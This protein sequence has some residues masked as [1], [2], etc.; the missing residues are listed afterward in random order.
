MTDKKKEIYDW[1]DA[2]PYAC[3]SYIDHDDTIVVEIKLDDE[4]END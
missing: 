3:L 2:C 4:E 1:I